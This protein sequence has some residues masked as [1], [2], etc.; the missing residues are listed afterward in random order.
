LIAHV[1]FAGHSTM[2]LFSVCDGHGLYGHHVSQFVKQWMPDN[3]LRDASL[4]RNPR[5]SLFRATTLCH[6]ELIRSGIDV[7]FSGTTMTMIYI[8]DSVLWCANVGDSRSLVARQITATDHKTSGRNWM[9]I[10]LSRDHK[11][12]DRDEFARI[13][14]KGGRV[15]AYQGSL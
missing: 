8:K 9:S 13:M 15:E 3:L 14:A 4:S 5:R 2:S 6:Q 1:N 10:S 7:N 11:P 12:D